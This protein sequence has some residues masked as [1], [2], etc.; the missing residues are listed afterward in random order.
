MKQKIKAFSRQV[1][2]ILAIVAVVIAV[3]TGT[4]EGFIRP[5]AVEYFTTN[6]DTVHATSTQVTDYEIWLAGEEGMTKKEEMEARLVM[7]FK[8]YQRKLLDDEIASLGGFR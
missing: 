8:K 3:T 2:I 5:V 7:E 6:T 4:Y 1:A